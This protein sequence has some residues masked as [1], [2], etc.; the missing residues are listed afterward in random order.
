MPTNSLDLL[1]AHALLLRAIMLNTPHLIKY[2]ANE[3]DW[4]ERITH[5]VRLGAA[6]DAYLKA[7]GNDCAQHARNTLDV[8]AFTDPVT[9]ALDDA[10]GQMERAMTPRASTT[11]C[12]RSEP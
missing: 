5:L 2:E 10:L 7:F 12:R 4:S 1:E 9:D 11:P 3:A 8:R 6:L